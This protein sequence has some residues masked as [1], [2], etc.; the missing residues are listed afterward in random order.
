MKIKNRKQERLEQELRVYEQN[1]SMTGKERKAL[2][3]WVGSGHSVY[4]NPGSRY[5]C[6]FGSQRLEFLDVYRQDREIEKELGG[7]T[8]KEK[9]SWLKAYMGYDEPT[10][11]VS[12]TPAQLKEHIRKLER[13][14]C[15]VWDYLGQEGLW[16]E[17]REYVDGH[18]D[19]AI[20]FE[21]L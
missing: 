20:P 13:E 2:R 7:K 17:A 1:I 5:L 14:L 6:D 12:P 8:Q 18:A 4:E 16:T 9:E 15:H 19:E 21:V 10:Q 3:E 11:E